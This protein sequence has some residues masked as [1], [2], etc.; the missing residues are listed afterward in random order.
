M[1][2]LLELLLVNIDEAYA[3][4]GWHGATLR[5]S[6]RGLSAEEVAW[7]PAQER[8][9]IWELVAH[10]AYWKFVARRRLGGGARGAFPLQRRDWIAA[11]AHLDDAAW[12]HVVRVLEE[13]HRLL[14]EVVAALSDGEL[15]EK[16]KQ[17]LVYGVAAHDVYHT[18]QIQLLK[19]LRSA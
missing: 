18:G 7:R 9:N 1:R 16:K 10:A 4:H 6:L 19:R 15:R 8:H 17:R 5:G 14:R 11:P 3:R 2:E 13:E 12:H